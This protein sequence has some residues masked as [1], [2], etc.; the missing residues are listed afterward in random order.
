MNL[1]F[2]QLRAVT[3]GAAYLHEDGDGIRFFRLNP[4]Q[5]EYYR[6]NNKGFFDKAKTTSG[7][8]LSFRT[9]SSSLFLDLTLEKVMGRSYGAVEIFVNGKKLN[10]LCNFD[11]EEMIGNFAERAYLGGR[12]TVKF[13]LPVGENLVRICLPRLI[14]VVIHEIALDD[15]AY[16]IPVKPANK[17]LVFGDSITQGFDC[18]WPTSHYLEYLCRELDGE[19]FNKAIGGEQHAP[20]LVECRENFNPDYIVVGYG[21]NDWRVAT[22]EAFLEMCRSFYEKLAQ[23]YP[24]V[25]VIAITPIWRADMEAVKDLVHFGSIHE[26]EAHIRQI[27]APYSNVTVIRGYEFIP[28]DPNMYGDLRLHPNDAGFT[29][30]GKS[31]VSAIHKM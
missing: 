27:T 1:D 13:P 11:K 4:Q 28:E 24:G 12:H 6:Q 5:M 19:E 23:Y 22:V 30:Y 15:G 21:T 7:I 17:V 26:I 18:L 8:A 10:A 2:E 31:L 9:D 16:I 25:P 3:C 14:G 20:F 29:H